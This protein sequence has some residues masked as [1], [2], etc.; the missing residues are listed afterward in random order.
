M[1]YKRYIAEAPVQQ[2]MQPALLD[3]SDKTI[4][5]I[6]K[7]INVSDESHLQTLVNN[8]KDD[9]SQ[10]ASM[11]YRMLRDLLKSNEVASNTK[12]TNTVKKGIE[13]LVTDSIKNK[14]ENKNGIK[15]I[16]DKVN[17]SLGN[18]SSNF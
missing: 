9:T 10:D 6:D 2:N 7:R 18:R 11:K 13:N 16:I 4:N 17:A 12:N 1:K 5:R 15:I 8:I 14:I 3:A